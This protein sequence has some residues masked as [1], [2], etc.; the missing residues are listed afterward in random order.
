M[1][2]ALA[3]VIL[4]MLGLASTTS[5]DL[6]ETGP[7]VQPT[8]PPGDT[9]WSSGW[10]DIEPGQVLT[11][12]HGLR[13]DALP[14]AVDLWSRDTRRQG[15]GVH[16]RAY[17]GMDIDG[18]R[19]GVHWQNLTNTTICVVREPDD[20][21][22]SQIRFL[23]RILDPL[24]YDSEWVDILPGQVVTLTHDLGGNVDDY[25]LGALLR[26][27]TPD[28]LGTHQYAAGGLEA[29][30]VFH[31]AAWQNLTDT[32]IEMVRFRDD[33]SAQQMRVIVRQPDAP[34]YDSNW[35]DIARGET[36]VIPHNLGGNPNFYLIR[37]SAWA[38]GQV[39]VGINTRAAG[40]L[41]IDGNYYGTNWQNL[42][43]DTI[44]IFRCSQDI[45][46]DQVRIRIWVMDAQ[47]EL[48]FLPFAVNAQ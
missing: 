25:T 19:Y 36:L 28:G 11:F 3:A 26:D 44:D 27:T 23:V 21:A 41:E 35:R 43:G 29:E 30:G 10:V 14:Y 12:T 15:F 6:A 18:Q 20:V 24:A 32:T 8:V 31:G 9:V 7:L 17:G 13:P 33:P 2:L 5:G 37:S 22:S 46:A 1:I 40:G 45:Y 39:G 47:E 42:T 38:T 16:H 48:L 4:A 34:D